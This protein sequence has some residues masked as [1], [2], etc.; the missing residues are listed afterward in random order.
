MK[1]LNKFGSFVTNAINP[2]ITVNPNITNLPLNLFFIK[3]PELIKIMAE[4]RGF[5]PP[6][7]HS[8]T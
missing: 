4:Q 1:N 8:P 7:Q 5:E 6:R 3:P 2:Y